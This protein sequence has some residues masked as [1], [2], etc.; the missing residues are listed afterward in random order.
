[1]A[2]EK[3]KPLL[4]APLM[5]APHIAPFDVMI[6]NNIGSDTDIAA[7]APGLQAGE[8]AWGYATILNIDAMPSDVFSRM[9]PLLAVMLVVD[10]YKGWDYATTEAEQREVLRKA[11]W[12]HILHGTPW[13]L[14]RS[15]ENAG[16]INVVI[17]E[18][19]SRHY[20]NGTHQLNGTHYLG[21]GRYWAEFN[22]DLQVP[23]GV[24]PLLVD[25]TPL[26]TLINYWKRAVCRLYQLRLNYLLITYIG[27]GHVG[28]SARRI[29]GTHMLNGT[30]AIGT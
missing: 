9:G 24:D 5:S 3:Q 15:L 22:V 26:V 25:V 13:A 19:L 30:Y 2:I 14:K 12:M 16:F 20:I 28:T 11:I 4:P 6:R 23:P 8:V 18:Y 17:D 29:D 1:M 27:I 21:T 10:G 7:F